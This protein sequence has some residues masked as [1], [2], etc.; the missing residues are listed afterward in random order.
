MVMILIESMDDFK[1]FTWALHDNVYVVDGLVPTQKT[2]RIAQAGALRRLKMAEQLEPLTH[3]C[4]T[5]LSYEHPFMPLT[6]LAMGLVSPFRG[7]AVGV[8]FL[9]TWM[10]WSSSWIP[11][12]CGQVHCV[13]YYTC[14][15]RFGAAPHGDAVKNT[16]GCS[17]S[18]HKLPYDEDLEWELSRRGAKSP[19]PELAALRVASGLAWAQASELWRHVPLLDAAPGGPLTSKAACAQ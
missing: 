15:F 4:K 14:P 2:C 18:L 19:R 16:F 5:M 8:F 1:C 11:L 9:G 6:L 13:W 12:P 7:V 10:G 3:T 17:A